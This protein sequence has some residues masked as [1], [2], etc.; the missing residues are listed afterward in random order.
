MHRLV[1]RSVVVLAV[2][3]AILLAGLPACGDEIVSTDARFRSP[4]LEDFAGSWVARTWHGGDFVD[5]DVSLE[6]RVG[7]GGEPSGSIV[8]G[9]E[10]APLSDISLEGRTLS[11][12][13]DGPDDI[14]AQGGGASL[15]F[16]PD[17]DLHATWYSTGACLPMSLSLERARP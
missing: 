2:V 12:S 6:L 9:N 7:R 16:G 10:R 13:W 4:R 8:D 17:G 1:S 5:S 3:A 14:I 11:L 15:A